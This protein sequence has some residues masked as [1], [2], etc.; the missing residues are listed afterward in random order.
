MFYLINYSCFSPL[1]RIQLRI[2]NI[3]ALSMLRDYVKYMYKGYK[4]KYTINIKDKLNLLKYLY[5]M[6]VS[7]Q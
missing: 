4:D 5:Q 3:S 1:V 2:M 7:E 6:N